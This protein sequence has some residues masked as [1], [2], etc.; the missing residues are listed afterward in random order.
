MPTI[1]DKGS[2]RSSWE[3][4]NGR[5]L[6]KIASQFAERGIF[7]DGDVQKRPVWVVV[8]AFVQGTRDRSWGA[9]IRA[10]IEYWMDGRMG[11][12]RCRLVSAGIRWLRSVFPGIG[13]YRPAV[14]VGI[15]RYRL[16]SA[17]IGWYGSVSVGILIISAGIGRYWLASAVGVVRAP[18]TPSQSA[19]RFGLPLMNWSSRVLSLYTRWPSTHNGWF[20]PLAVG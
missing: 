1:G 5:G 7:S 16:L 4:A 15:N 13:W 12:G 6:Q 18:K 14:S 3:R 17:G 10:W 2:F 9:V 20:P 19:K 11:I 8:E